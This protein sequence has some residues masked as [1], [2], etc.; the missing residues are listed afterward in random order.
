MLS[1]AAGRLSSASKDRVRAAR[2]GTDGAR[3]SGRWTGRPVKRS[4][5][6]RSPPKDSACVC[7][8]RIRNA[9]LSVTVMRFFTTWKTEVDTC[10]FRIWRR[11][12]RPSRSTTAR[13]LKSACLG[14]EYGYS[15]D[16]PDGLVAWEAQFGDFWNAAQMIVDQ[17]IAAAEDKWRRLSGITLCFRMEWKGRDRNIPARGWNVFSNWPPT[18]ISRSSIRRR[19]R[20]CFIV[21]G[22]RCCADGESRLS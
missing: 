3:V 15:L 19:P 1:H 12:R 11:I 8:D 10:R 7:P 9:E 5:S 13:F 22:D 20:N 17:F 6:L 21:C 4:R 16:T 18:T 14:F 2:C